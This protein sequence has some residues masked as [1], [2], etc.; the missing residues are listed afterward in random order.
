MKS[1]LMLSILLCILISTT[2]VAQS[3]KKASKP[4][5]QGAA[6]TLNTDHIGTWKLVSQKITYDNGQI[7]L[8]DSTNVFQRLII[9]PTTCVVIGE[10][11][12]PDYDNKKL[13]ISVAGGHY[14]LIDG[15]YRYRCSLH[16]TRDLK[17]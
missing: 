2:V 6:K 15:K 16:P 3:Q 5:K 4:L 10:A 17:P 14:T 1:K 13:A 7:F 11:K 8:G 9:T 12:I